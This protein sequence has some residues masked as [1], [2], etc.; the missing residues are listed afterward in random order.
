MEDFLN[1]VRSRRQTKAH[2]D[3]AHNTASLIHLGEI[4]YRTKTVL[5]F[6][7]K[8]ETITG[9]ARQY[10]QAL[11]PHTAG[12]AYVNFMM[13][14]GQERIQ[15]TYRDNYERLTQVKKKYDPNNL[16]R[17]NQNIKPAD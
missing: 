9:W 4:A 2:V 16:F 11:Q 12:A 13:D 3:I 15:A 6:D 7:A 14:E 5:E 10:W 1:C 8:A 17:V